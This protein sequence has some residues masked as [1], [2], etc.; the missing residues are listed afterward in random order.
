MPRISGRSLISETTEKVLR[1]TLVIASATILT[2]LYDVPLNDLKV[3]GMELPAA[4]YDS[5]LLGLV[6]YYMYS[7]TINWAGDLAAFRLWYT[8]SSIWSN[9]GSNM[10]L[11][12][13]FIRGAVPLILKLHELEQ[14]RSWPTTFELLPEVDRRNFADF[15]A[16]VELYTH[17]LE[18]AGSRFFL[19]S[20]FGHYYVWFQSY[21]FPMMLCV[22]A[23]FLQF[24]YGMFSPPA[25][26]W[27]AT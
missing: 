6:V 2:K 14:N 25:K 19:L 27:G 24:K 22:G 18:H 1:R 21:V 17:R 16:N 9:F 8:E 5:V 12:K 15:K 11:D 4:L 26:I 7:L 23:L 13:E 10:T 3:L 20:K